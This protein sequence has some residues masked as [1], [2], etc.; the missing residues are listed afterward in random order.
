MKILRCWWSNPTG[1]NFLLLILTS[2]RNNTKLTTLPTLCNYGRT[3][4][5]LNLVSPIFHWQHHLWIP[6]MTTWEGLPSLNNLEKIKSHV[7]KFNLFLVF[8]YQYAY[9]TIHDRDCLTYKDLHSMKSD[10]TPGHENCKAWCN[11]RYHC[12]GFALHRGRCYLKSDKCRNDYRIKV[13]VDLVLKYGN[14][15]SHLKKKY[16]GQWLFWKIVQYSF[17]VQYDIFYLLICDISY[18]EMYHINK[19]WN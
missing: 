10:G 7:S 19:C 3:L 6:V 9:N 18:F 16:H 13:G 2:L 15:L 5:V 14:Y 12:Q 11:Q 4:F 17:F 1:A 8:R